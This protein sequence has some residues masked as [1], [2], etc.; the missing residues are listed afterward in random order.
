MND[1]AHFFF[2]FFGFVGFV[3]LF[4]ST[5]FFFDIISAVIN[6]SLGCLMFAII[7]RQILALLLD[8]ETGTS[9]NS[10]VVNEGFNQNTSSSSPDAKNF[11]PAQS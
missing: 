11:T 3:V 1:N 7:G 4:C 10:E 6:G 8:Q 5:I 2:F 9:K